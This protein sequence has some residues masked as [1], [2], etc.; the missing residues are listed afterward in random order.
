VFQGDWL[1]TGDT[2][3]RDEDGFYQC[4]GRSHDMIKAGGIWVSPMEVEAR[5]VQHPSVAEAAVVAYVGPD[6]LEK[7]VACVVPGPGRQVDGEELI[8]F[9]REGLASFKRPREVLVLDELPKT[10]TGKIQRVVVRQIA[11]D[12]LGK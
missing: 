1:R 11:A 7:P 5:L 9:C 12:L 4:L 6:G 10:A 3:I 8:A 2:Y